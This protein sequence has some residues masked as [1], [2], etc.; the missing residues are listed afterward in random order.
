MQRILPLSDDELRQILVYADSLEQHEAASHLEDLMGDSPQS[1][2]F[3]ASYTKHRESRRDQPPD[4]SGS[5]HKSDSKGA[6]PAYDS[7]GARSS[8][9][10]M[11]HT[12]AFIE[13]ARVRA[14]DEVSCIHC[15]S[16]CWLLTL[17]P[18]RDTA[19]ATDTAV[20]IWHLQ[21]RGRA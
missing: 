13:A 17:P 8:T 21:Q 14:R 12:N 6:P 18:A 3:I 4:Y 5:S 1:K 11:P 9:R 2:E 19:N 16:A 15:V 20:P 10:S 7:N